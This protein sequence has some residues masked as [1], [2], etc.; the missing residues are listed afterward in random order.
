MPAPK[1]IAIAQVAMHW[2]LDD[3]VS[4]ITRALDIAKAHGASIC[5]FSELAVTGFHRQVPALA[6]PALIEPVVEQVRQHCARLSIAA[7]I[8]APTFN[9]DGSQRYIT[10]LLVDQTGTLVAAVSKQGLTAP[11]ATVFARGSTRPIGTLQGLRCT[12]VICRE[13]SDQAVLAQ[14]LPPGVVD[15]V[16]VPG[17]LRQDPN[18]PRSDPPPYVQDLQALARSTRAYVVQTNWPNALNRPEEGE[19]GG[20]SAVVSPDGALL[21]RLPRAASGLGL[22]ELGRSEFEWIVP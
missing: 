14:Q 9:A 16:F 3:N 1:R 11:E 13:I 22:F 17:A 21:L 4:A 6:A 18:L 2:T 15:L 8:G 19:D 20:H 7:S 12:A 5:A 10:Q